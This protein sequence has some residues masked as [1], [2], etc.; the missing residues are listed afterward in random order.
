MRTP[1]FIALLLVAGCAPAGHVELQIADPDLPFLEPGEDFD[2]LVVEARRDG[3][4]AVEQTYTARALP[5]VLTVVPGACFRGSIELRAGATLAGRLRA[6]SRWLP[7]EFPGDGAQVLTATLT[8][9][10]GRRVLYE[11]GYEDGEPFAGE[12]SLPRIRRAG[13]GDFEAVISEVRPITGMRS[14]RISGTASVADA[15]AFARI[16]ALNHEVARGDELLFTMELDEGAEVRS[17]GIDLELSTG[18]TARDLGLEDA[19]GHPVHAGS[20]EGR[21][22]GVARRVQVDLTPAAGARLVGLLVGVDV[23]QAM[24]L[25]RFDV[26]VDELTVVRP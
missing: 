12:L 4:P 24:V 5:A 22:L 8:D 18:A 25:G 10:A 13:V 16:A 3:C 17:V 1:G 14:A 9:V 19:E 21:V 2:Q 7:V 15:H 26:R 20:V 6:R 11:T 23:S